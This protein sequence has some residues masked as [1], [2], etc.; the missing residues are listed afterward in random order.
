M[1]EL[2]LSDKPLTELDQDRLGY[3]N[4]AKGI[5]DTICKLS[6]EDELVFGLFAPWGSGKTTCLNFI[7]KHIKNNNS[8]N[9]PIILRFNP[10]W[11]S[12]DSDLIKQFFKELKFSLGKKDNMKK[13]ADKLS[14]LGEA[15]SNIPEPTGIAKITGKLL[16][17][18]KKKEVQIWDLKNEISKL[19]IKNDKGILVI[20]D[21]IDRLST[22]EIKNLFKVIKSIA[23]FPKIIYLLSF[24]KKI[25]SKALEKIQDISGEQYLEKIIQVPYELPMPDKISLRTYF[26]SIIG[27]IIEKTS[28]SLFDTT[29]WG[30]VFWEGIDHF[31]QNV[32]DIKRLT[33][34]I[35][36]TYPAIENEVNP[37]DYIAIET[38]RVFTPELYYI[39]RDNPEM[40]T[41]VYDT[42]RDAR[43]E[44]EACK[45]FHESLLLN[46]PERDKGTIKKML[47]RLFPKWKMSFE[48]YSYGFEFLSIWRKELKIC[49]PDIFPV[50]F[51]FCL[52]QG[53]ILNTEMQSILSSVNN[54]EVFS[55][56][57]IELSKRHRT[58]GSTMLSVFLERLEDYTK[59]D[60]GKCYIKNILQAFFNIGDKL[61]LPEDNTNSFFSYDNDTRIGRI[62]FQLLKRFDSHNERFE[63]LQ[64]VFTNGQS[65]SIIASKVLV[66]GQQHGKYGGKEKNN[67][68]DQLVTNEQLE[69]LEKI[70]VT[71]IK[72]AA[73][74]NEILKTPLLSRLFYIW[75]ELEGKDAPKNWI[76]KS[77]TLTNDENIAIIL[78]AFLSKTKSQSVDDVVMKTRWRLPFRIIEPYISP[79]NIIDRCRQ[80]INQSPEWLIGEKKIAVE[81]FV[82]EFENPVKDRLI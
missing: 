58:D 17:L 45:R 18:F 36:V 29:Y 66:L 49:S 47:T 9:N 41:G 42:Y 55:R 72:I 8:V 56:N 74:V 78:S 34:A 33:N 59:E 40:F 24:D 62:F 11:F 21:D 1:N 75:Q 14:S 64:E 6:L 31:L 38:I 30:N 65:L 2:V 37:I 81:T 46:I 67:E 68:N 20:I 3:S 10:W 60:I 32:R 23:D 27:T 80:I 48:N 25:V 50:F 16:T 77:N 12:G 79:Q 53:Q 43:Y 73:S 26:F 57:L 51:K 15:V 69:K 28:E 5:A 52:P 70:A 13:I 35:K 61:L 82:E 54:V 76:L 39:I 7:V 44:K 71:K 19:L 22:D 4:F 63:I